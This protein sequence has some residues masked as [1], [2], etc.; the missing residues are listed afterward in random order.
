MPAI[1]VGCAHASVISVRLKTTEIQMV[2]T[3]YL[4][5]EEVGSTLLYY[6]S[7]SSGYRNRN[8]NI[9]IGQKD[10]LKKMRFHQTN[11]TCIVLYSYLRCAT[12]ISPQIHFDCFQYLNFLTDDYMLHTLVQDFYAKSN[13][14]QSLVC[15]RRLSAFMGLFFFFETNTPFTRQ[16]HAGNNAGGKSNKSR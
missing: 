6:I 12:A 15:G 10:L 3:Y 5:L 7:R 16:S 4:I 13:I 2:I 11:M 8:P 14:N 1:A 9:N